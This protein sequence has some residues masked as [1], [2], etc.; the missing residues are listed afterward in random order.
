MFMRLH[1][2]YIGRHV[3][4]VCLCMRLG[5]LFLFKSAGEGL[6]GWSFL[7]GEKCK[8]LENWGEDWRKHGGRVDHPCHPLLLLPPASHL[9]NALL[10]TVYGRA[11]QGLTGPQVKTSGR[12]EWRKR[13]E[14]EFHLRITDQLFFS[15]LYNDDN[16]GCF[17]LTHASVLCIKAWYDVRTWG[18]S[19]YR[20][21]RS[22]LSR[23]R[24]MNVT[25]PEQ[26]GS[27]QAVWA[28][29]LKRIKVSVSRK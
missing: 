8:I 13:R 4:D 28:V 3:Q 22:H 15:W 7:R 23:W 5:H 21:S 12:Q 14:R 16:M 29:K 19:T 10:P 26:R 20:H 6:W 1:F 18:E 17:N 11:P 27:K 25:E 2:G 24:E 9:I